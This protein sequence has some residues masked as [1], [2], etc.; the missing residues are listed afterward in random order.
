[1]SDLEF[2]LTLALL[3][4][5]FG[6]WCLWLE[7]RWLARRLADARAETSALVRALDEWPAAGLG[8]SV[9]SWRQDRD[10]TECAG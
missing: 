7:C 9:S 10:I 8:H 1:M 4:T 5:V 2:Y 6:C 3:G